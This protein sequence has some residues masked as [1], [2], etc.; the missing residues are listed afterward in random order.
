MERQIEDSMI[1][2]QEGT[3]S[4]RK[5]GEYIKDRAVIL[6]DVALVVG[7][8][9]L[10]TAGFLLGP[11]VGIGTI[12][13]GVAGGSAAVATIHKVEKNKANKEK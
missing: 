12:V 13:A 6:R 11:L 7:G 8:G 3:K 9:V 5:A 1:N 10:G 2:T 4:L